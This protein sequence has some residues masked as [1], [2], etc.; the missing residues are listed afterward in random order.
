MTF[1]ALALLGLP[2][3]AFEGL[4]IRHPELVTCLGR[5]V[6]SLVAGPR[7]PFLCVAVLVGVF[8]VVS[9]LVVFLLD[10]F[11]FLFVPR[12]LLASKSLCLTLR[13]RCLYRWIRGCR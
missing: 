9:N 10:I 2:G 7:G 13:S 5:Q 11:E 12:F 1:F 8:P 4:L 6:C 3:L